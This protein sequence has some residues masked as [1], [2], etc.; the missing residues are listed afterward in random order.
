MA[1]E[2][3]ARPPLFSRL[4]LLIGTFL[5][6][7]LALIA[8]W[9]LRGREWTPTLAPVVVLL[10]LMIVVPLGQFVRSRFRMSLRSALVLMTALAIVL[11]GFGT[12]ANRARVQRR[13][14]QSVRRLARPIPNLFEQPEAS[15]RYIR[16][17]DLGG[18]LARG[19]GGWIVPSWMVDLLG[20]DFFFDV[21]AV[22]IHS[23]DLLDPDALADVELEHFEQVSLR[24]CLIGMQSMERLASMPR[25]RSLDLTL[26]GIKDVHLKPLGKLEH[27]ETLYLGNAWNAPKANIITDEGLSHLSGLTNLKHLT[28]ECTGVTARG[29]EQLKSLKELQLLHLHRTNISNEDVEMIAEMFPKLLGLHLGHT[30]VDEDAIPI[31]RSMPE[32]Q[33][34]TISPS[35]SE[36]FESLEREKEDR[37]AGRPIFYYSER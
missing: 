15:V 31:L 36:V 25:L 37:D 6:C 29:L 28:L 14:V 30:G 12:T 33:W 20:E 18:D 23:Q 19:R 13:A 24:G 27:L 26:A 1:T 21:Q 10:T 16:S 4:S 7:I 8:T 2:I 35:T 9:I 3:T 32:L 11:G 5:A 17:N 22:A 34:V